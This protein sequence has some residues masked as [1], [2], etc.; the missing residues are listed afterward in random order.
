MKIYVTGLIL[1]LDLIQWK[2]GEQSC[3]DLDNHE[4]GSHIILASAS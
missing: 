4:Q 2:N 3:S 1:F